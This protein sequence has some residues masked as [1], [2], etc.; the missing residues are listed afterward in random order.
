MGHPPFEN[1]FQGTPVWEC[2][3][4]WTLEPP[5]LCETDQGPQRPLPGAISSFY[6]A[7]LCS[8]QLWRFHSFRLPCEW[9][10]ELSIHQPYSL[11]HL[12]GRGMK[13]KADYLGSNPSSQLISWKTPGKIVILFVTQFLHLSNVDSHSLILCIKYHAHYILYTVYL[14]IV[15]VV[16]I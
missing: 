8:V 9:Q 11:M 5:K 16:I 2:S 6:L 13:Q 4:K 3:S 7:W 10:S 12:R 14:Y 15:Y 1:S